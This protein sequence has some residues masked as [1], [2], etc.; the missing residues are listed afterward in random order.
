MK[1]FLCLFFALLMWGVLA[2]TGIAEE[3]AKAGDPLKSPYTGRTRVACNI[4]AEKDTDSDILICVP[5]GKRI[6]MYSFDPTWAEV[7]YDGKRGYVKRSLLESCHVRTGY[8]EFYPPYGVEEYMYRAV[9]SG[10]APV[11]SE[12]GSDQVLTILHDGANIAFIGFEDGWGKLIYRRQYAYISSNDLRDVQLVDRD[13]SD[14]GTGSPVAVYVSFYNIADTE[15]NR[16]RMINLQVACDRLNALIF[17]PGDSLNFN[18]QIGPYKASVGYQPAP[19]LISGSTKLNYGG[20][21]CQVSSTLYNTILQLPGITILQ[22]RP[23]GPSGAAYLPHGVDAAVGN[24]QL[25]LRFRNDYPYSIRIDG[26][27]QDGA[28]YIAVYRVK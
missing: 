23:H 4:R 18:T 28:L 14:P 12:K 21:T 16:A 24:S 20:G 11:L 27:C 8:Y 10:D 15:D 26:H 22:R 19:A 17:A 6:P 3:E 9:I 1:R 2:F 25:N 13:L 5:K 7:E